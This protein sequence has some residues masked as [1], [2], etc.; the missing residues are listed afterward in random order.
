MEDKK[1]IVL[2]SKTVPQGISAMMVVDLDAD[3]E[4]NTEAM[5]EALA[6]VSTSEVTYAARDS[7]FDGFAIT[8]GDYMALVEH[9]LFATNKDLTA[10]M[11]Q[12]A[13]SEKHQEAEFISIFYGED[14][15]EEDAQKIEALFAAACPN[16]EVSLLPGGQPVYYYMISAE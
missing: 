13:A 12:L 2:P 7:D 1:V 15:T 3:E 6:N 16:A 4:A 14:V 11:E 10:L 9:Q 5:T 8:Q